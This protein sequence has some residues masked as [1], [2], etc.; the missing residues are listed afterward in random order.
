MPKGGN[1]GGKPQPS[2]PQPGKKKQ[3]SPIPTAY[4]WWPLND[5]PSTVDVGGTKDLQARQAAPFSRYNV[6]AANYGALTF[7]SN[8]SWF[9]DPR[10]GGYV[11]NNNFGLHAA[12]Q[13][14]HAV[15]FVSFGFE[16][17][18]FSVWARASAVPAAANGAVAYKRFSAGDAFIIRLDQ[19]TMKWEFVY[20]SGGA[21]HTIQSLAAA[22]LNRWYHLATT[23]DA[24]NVVRFYVDGALQGTFT[25]APSGNGDIWVIGNSNANDRLFAGFIFSAMGFVPQFGGS[26]IRALFLAP[27]A[28]LSPPD[29][30]PPVPGGGGPTPPPPTQA[31]RGPLIYGKSVTPVAQRNQVAS[32]HSGQKPLLQ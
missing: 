18:T 5:G 14:D 20:G 7:A 13:T 23:I 30:S 22:N 2:P 29:P 16:F 1:T 4:I 27:T 26:Q 12:S 28:P 15:T 31:G 6:A 3:V 24:G 17:R 11:Y 9:Y 21:D 19:A 8:R 10:M 25:G 32:N